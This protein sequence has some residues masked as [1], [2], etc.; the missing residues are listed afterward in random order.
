MYEDLI[1][2]AQENGVEVIE[3]NFKGGLKGLYSQNTIAINSKLKTSKEKNCVLAEELGHHYTSSGN[4]LNI[5]DIKN[6]KQEKRA[7]NWGYEKL[8]GVIDIVNSFKQGIKNR[9]DMAEH[10][11]VTEEFLDASIH[12]YREKYGLYCEIDHYIVYFEPLGVVEM[13]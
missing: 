2:E 12:H 5:K 6:V 4:I 13:F 11:N 10:L 8:V 7:R 1:S 3:I 9:H